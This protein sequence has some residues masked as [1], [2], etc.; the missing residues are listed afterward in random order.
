MRERS[1]SPEGESKMEHRVLHARWAVA[2]LT[3]T[4]LFTVGTAS[5]Q[6]TCPPP[7]TTCTHDGVAAS[8]EVF[9]PGTGPGI[10]DQTDSTL[11]FDLGDVDLADGV[12]Q[13]VNIYTTSG[14]ISLFRIRAVSVSA[15]GVSYLSVDSTAD[16]AVDVNGGPPPNRGNSYDLA[17]AHLSNARFVAVHAT[18][19][20]SFD[21]TAVQGVNLDVDVDGDG[22]VA[23]EEAAIGTDPRD[24]DTDGDGIDDLTEANSC[25]TDPLDPD[26]DGD[27]VL[28]GA[29]VCHGH[30]DGAD[31]D[32]DGTPDGCDLCV[33]DDTTG[34]T[35]GDAICDD[36]DTCFGDNSTGDSDDD[37]TCDD[38][39]PCPLDPADDADGDGVCGDVDLCLGDDRSGDTD[40]DQVCDD[41]DQ[42][43][44]NDAA[45]D[46]DGDRVCDDLDNCPLDDNADQADSDGDGIGDACETDGDG[47]GIDDDVDNCPAAPNPGQEDLDSDGAGDACDDD[48]DGDGHA[49]GE[50]NCPLIANPGQ[51]D[52]DGDGTGDACDGDDDADGVPDEDDLCP[53]T[54]LEVPFDEDG[55][56]GVQRVELVCGAPADY[57]QPAQHLFC[58]ISESRAAWRAGLLTAKERAMLVREAALALL[59][60]LLARWRP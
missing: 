23:C 2:C 6:G 46:T 28:D 27:G 14:L 13:D 4:L 56:S 19:L 39:D 21:H 15:D 51:E 45:G 5:A 20:A 9:E 31:G 3:S 52:L 35:D 57:D 54:P 12:G 10:F 55:C 48:D 7:S 29:D 58:V 36:T 40:M 60:I 59:A 53:G 42:C 11:I 34:D 30:D 43:F 22:I 16:A 33:G 25:D 44:G 50:D 26:T 41:S 37:G 49:D 17:G 8:L 18:V 24:A 38:S 32:G 47:D 1:L